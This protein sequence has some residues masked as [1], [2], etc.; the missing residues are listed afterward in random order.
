M[1]SGP[2]EA[3]DEAASGGLPSGGGCAAAG[4]PKRQRQWV[5]RQRTAGRPPLVQIRWEGRPG[6]GGRAVACDFF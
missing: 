5:G 2:A 1:G 3:A 4:L 6:G